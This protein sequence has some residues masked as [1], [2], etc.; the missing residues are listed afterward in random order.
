MSE[1]I[2]DWVKR[3]GERELPIFKY[4][5]TAIDQGVES[6]D[7]STT[8]LAQIIL[9]DTSLT[10]RIL[11]LA[12]SVIYNPTNVPISTISRAILFIGFDMV[13]NISLS[14]AIIDSLLKTRSREH[15]MK[16]MAKSFHGAAL[17][18]Q[19]AKRRG[20]DATEEVFIAALLS[21]VG[22]MAFWCVA[23]DAGERI[24]KLAAEE[25]C[26]A[27]AAQEK[28]LGFNFDQL[29]LALTRNW[30]MSDLL[31]SSINNPQ[32]ANPRIRDINLSKSL[33]ESAQS[34]WEDKNTQAVIKKI[35]GHLKLKESETEKLVRR[36]AKE[37][38]ETIREY[39]AIEILG[40]LPILSESKT[41]QDD[42]SDEFLIHEYPE[43]DPLLQLAILKDLGSALETGPTPNVILEII[44]E[45]I[46]RG[47]GMDR[48]V[49]ALLSQD[50]T[51][52]TDKYSISSNNQGFARPFKFSAIENNIFSKAL[53]EGQALWVQDALAEQYKNLIDEDVRRIL[54]AESFMLY[55]IVI[56]GK[57]IGLI[58]ADRKPSEREMDMD[59]FADFK[60]FGQQ[61]C[62][63]IEH[64]SKRR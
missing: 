12:N 16:L 30:R 46:N 14:L 7:T 56:D 31:Q 17:A 48:C 38:A 61:A 15:V 62:L 9:H 32:L 20:D 19:L 34:G 36:Q 27:K 44:L 49:F 59:M 57:P 47:V 22:E 58:Y 54:E 3:I 41:G 6:E 1:E 51:M 60:Q 23:E 4:T 24:L 25:G 8:E 35:A 26:T 42:S 5:A 37:V 29:T 13:R 50:K 18:Q 63:A 28:L 21:S 33:A 55:P 45:G 52:L 43:A 2:E 53:K 10:S 11:R 64:I 40:Y 39:G